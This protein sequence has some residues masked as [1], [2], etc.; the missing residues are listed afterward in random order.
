MTNGNRTSYLLQAWL[1]IALAACSGTLL[2]LAQIRLSPVI[3]ANKLKETLTHVP[4]L[5]Y[6][7]QVPEPPAFEIRK[8]AVAGSG[9]THAVY[10]ARLNGNIGG[11]VVAASGQGYA[12]PIELLIGLSPRL[13]T[14]T[15]LYVL[16]QQETPGLGSKIAEEAFR[17]QFIGKP[18]TGELTAV[19]KG[20][21]A[22]N[23][24]DAVTGATISS[25]SVC[26]IVNEAVADLREPLRTMDLPQQPLTTTKG[27]EK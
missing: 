3:E 2:A 11:W 24:I 5:V 14:V 8:L 12:G 20:K 9:K 6:G 26:A 27:A 10:E 23:A 1:V 16:M 4:S 21:T 22:G 13:D 18:A 17:G 25:R 15:G 7:D 19:A